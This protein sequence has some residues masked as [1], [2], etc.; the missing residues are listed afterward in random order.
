M[1]AAVIVLCLT[2]LAGCAA[3]RPPVEVPAQ[4]AP[5]P[6]ASSA[7]VKSVKVGQS[8][9]KGRQNDVLG[10]RTAAE[11]RYM[12]HIF[13]ELTPGYYS[14]F[15]ASKTGKPFLVIKNEDGS[16]GFATETAQGLAFVSADVRM[17]SKDFIVFSKPTA[18][19]VS[20]RIVTMYESARKTATEV[21]AKQL[22][23]PGVEGK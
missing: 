16:A 11:A 7:P 12:E 14:F 9:P 1:R 8:S 15:K 22:P 23:L 18:Q 20:E 2:V 6:A 10:V 13:R 17:Q 4:Q 21:A 19:P 5:V 3:K